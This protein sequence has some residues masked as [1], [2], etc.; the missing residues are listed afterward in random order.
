[1]RTFMITLLLTLAME[2]GADTRGFT[3]YSKEVSGK[4]SEYMSFY[5][6]SNDQSTVVYAYTSTRGEK[7]FFSSYS[8]NKNIVVWSEAL[9]ED[10]KTFI[11]DHKTSQLYIPVFML[12]KARR[13]GENPTIWM[14]LNCNKEQDSVEFTMH[15]SLTTIALLTTL[16]SQAEAGF[17]KNRSGWEELTSDAQSGYVMGAYDWMSQVAPVEDN[18]SIHNCVI[19]I[20][21]NSSDMI[22]VVNNFYSDLSKWEAPPFQALLLG[23]RKV[24]SKYLSND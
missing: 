24:C 17:V 1:M 8:E 21:F 7:S 6:L 5:L 9:E 15:T 23:L 10:A 16:A 12:A 3:C 4:L 13:G 19:N 18:L 20:G 14:E 2:A 11:F 22:E